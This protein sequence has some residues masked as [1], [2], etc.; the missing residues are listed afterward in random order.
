MPAHGESGFASLQYAAVRPSSGRRVLFARG[1]AQAFLVRQLSE[2]VRRHLAAGGGKFWFL[3]DSVAQKFQVFGNRPVCKSD[4][5]SGK[6]VGKQVTKSCYGGTVCQLSETCFVDIMPRFPT[7]YPQMD[8]ICSFMLQVYNAAL[9]CLT[10][11]CVEAKVPRYHGSGRN[12]VPPTCQAN[13]ARHTD[14]K[15]GKTQFG[16]VHQR[17][18]RDSFEAV[19]AWCQAAHFHREACSFPA[20][21]SLDAGHGGQNVCVPPH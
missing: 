9:H 14:G 2:T 19:P 7:V 20:A 18:A 13:H 11:R 12:P 4:H 8:N 10:F 6:Q 21:A 3:H 5:G 16:G 17:H 1:A 15:S